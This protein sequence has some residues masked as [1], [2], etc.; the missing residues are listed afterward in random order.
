[1]TFGDGTPIL[2]NRPTADGIEV[3]ATAEDALASLDRE[4]SDNNRAKSVA[5][6]GRRSLATTVT[7]DSRVEDDVAQL[8]MSTLSFQ[9]YVRERMLRRRQ[10]ASTESSKAPRFSESPPAL[11]VRLIHPAECCTA[12]NPFSTKHQLRLP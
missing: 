12:Q 3:V 7:P 1:M 9:D 11:A 4:D 10:D 6:D 5:A 2:S 8:S